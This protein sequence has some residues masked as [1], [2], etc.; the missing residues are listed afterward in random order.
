MAKIPEEK[1]DE[2]R[3]SVNVVHYISQ[4][5]NLKKAGQNYKGL[6]PFH[7]EKTPS[8]VVSPD[9]QIYHCF[10]CG[11]GGNIF[12]FIM[13]YEKLSF[14]EAVRRAAEFA[15]IIL[16]EYRDERSPEEISYF[17]R[18]Y[19]INESACRFFEQA[20]YHPG[21]KKWL[22][23]LT[24]R[25]ISEAT[26]KTFRI[27]YA[28][29]SYEKLQAHLKKEGFPIEDCAKLG[30][31][32]KKE[33]GSGYFDKFRHRIIFPFQNISGKILGFGGRKL[34]ENQPAKY[35]N[36]PESPIYK[37]GEL[38]YGLHQAID[39]IRAKDFVVLVEGYFDLLR[40]VENQFRNAVA[41]S[42]TALTPTQARLI[43]RYTKNVRIAYDGDSAGIKA[44]IRNGFILEKEG[45]N[46]TIT[47]LPEGE[48]PDSFVLEQGIKPF[49][50]LLESGQ[51]PLDF[52]IEAFFAETP[53]PS[54]QAKEQFLTETLQE[55]SDLKN[56]LRLG[57]YIHRLAEAF[58]INEQALVDQMRKL[59]RFR[60]KNEP[61]PAEQTREAP[62]DSGYA[63]TG[64]H[65]AEAGIIGLLLNGQPEVRNFIMQSVSFDLFEN[66]PL[67]RIY[68]QIMMELE[69][70]GQIDAG[71]FLLRFQEDEPMKRLLSEIA[72]QEYKDEMKFARDCIFQ[73]KKW[74]LEKKSRELQELIRQESA[75][76]DSVL[77][78]S[79]ELI[80]V[81]RQLNELTKTHQE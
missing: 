15:G 80:A 38:L 59:R 46:V 31:V 20:L 37:K 23:Y 51:S 69:E 79:Q 65:R 3:S 17:D 54:Y 8:F 11:K 16:P 39:A 55:L 30:L 53:N 64:M 71:K 36:S 76:S 50:K 34:R 29:D 2:I 35:L 67:I 22:R 12:S 40:L 41:S 45:L 73:L 1:I 21:A 66:E 24:D 58:Q 62:Q 49:E 27:G 5:V 70:Y 60:K 26:I 61:L 4:Y 14:G 32:Q 52:R 47:A 19:A 78:Y 10:G 75:S 9:K 28:P 44:A 13:E 33:H 6:C 77:H 63:F 48:D 74:Q 42:G 25:H 72:L 68:D 43:R 7:T 56:A 81:R 57:H 18:L